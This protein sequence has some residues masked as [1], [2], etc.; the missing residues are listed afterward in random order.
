MLLLSAT[1]AVFGKLDSPENRTFSYQHS[2]KNKKLTAD[3]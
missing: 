1:T 2:A 3:R